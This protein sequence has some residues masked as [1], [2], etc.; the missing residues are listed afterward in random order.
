M[1]LDVMAIILRIS[2]FCLFLEEMRVYSENRNMVLD[3]RDSNIDAAYISSVQ[4]E[5][6]SPSTGKNSEQVGRAVIV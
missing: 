1:N 4:N 3:I 6:D 2:A 5:S